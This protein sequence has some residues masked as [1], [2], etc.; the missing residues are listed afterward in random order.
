MRYLSTKLV[1]ALKKLPKILY[2]IYA[3]LRIIIQVLQMVYVLRTPYDYVIMQ[4]PP[5]IPLLFVAVL[6]KKFKCGRM[7][8]IIDWHNYGYTIL[9]VNHVNRILVFFG[10]IYEKFFGKFGDYHLCVSETMK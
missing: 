4:N 8:L 6:M 1:D 9:R 5:C 3:I 2:L 10:K 7:K